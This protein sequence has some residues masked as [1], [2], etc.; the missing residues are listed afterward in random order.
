VLI[1]CASVHDVVSTK[2][3]IHIHLDV[4]A[5][6]LHGVLGVVVNV[7]N[8]VGQIDRSVGR[9]WFARVSRL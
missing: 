6:R 1:S 4:T 2:H 8:A 5:Y 7:D 3:N 9:C